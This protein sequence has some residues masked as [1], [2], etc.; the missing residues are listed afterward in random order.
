MQRTVHAP[1]QVCCVCSK[2]PLLLFSPPF[3][4]SLPLSPC[5]SLFCCS[6]Q[7]SWTRCFSFLFSTDSGMQL[8]ERAGHA[9]F[10]RVSALSSVS[11]RRPVSGLVGSWT[12][13]QVPLLP[14]PLPPLGLSR[15]VCRN[16]SQARLKSY[17]NQAI[18]KEMKKTKTHCSSHQFGASSRFFYYSSRA[19]N[20]A[21]SLHHH[22]HACPISGYA[23]PG[24]SP[25]FAP[26]LSVVPSGQW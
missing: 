2:R 23:G 17:T 16:S 14:L 22:C 8:N 3:F 13:S 7:Q 25:A 12:R 4:L 11:A 9:R 21:G 18:C 19:S 10:A 26:G 1:L 5:N 24:V 6:L 15:Q 20:A